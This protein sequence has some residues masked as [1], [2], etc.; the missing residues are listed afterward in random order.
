MPWYF[1]TWIV[2]SSI[3]GVIYVIGI[4]ATCS[5]WQRLRRENA[6][7]TSVKDEARNALMW[8]GF[9]F[10]VVLFPPIGI[11]ALLGLII[12][13]VGRGFKSL[14]TDAFKETV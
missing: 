2:L 10:P 5:E 14:I 7:D 6:S 3:C 11:V 9:A 1:T 13:C 8:I 4:F 12:Y